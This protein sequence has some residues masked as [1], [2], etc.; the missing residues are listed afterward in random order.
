MTFGK[1][2]QAATTQSAQKW[3]CKS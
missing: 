3:F 2:F 1:L